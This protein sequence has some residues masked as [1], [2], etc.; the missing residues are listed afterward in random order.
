MGIRNFHGGETL[1]PEK[2]WP[3]IF[4]DLAEVI[5]PYIITGSGA[6]RSHPRHW[7]ITCWGGSPEAWW[8]TPRRQEVVVVWLK[9]MFSRPSQLLFEW[10]FW[11]DHWFSLVWVYILNNFRGL[12]F[13]WSWT[14]NL[15]IFMYSN[16]TASQ[17]ISK[18]LS[19]YQ[20]A[21]RVFSLQY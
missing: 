13:Q 12:V 1:G 2:K 8:V 7:I 14:S 19:L 11:K 3:K 17:S 18:P 9:N 5:S 4:S 15:Y 20:H 6:H 16:I 21:N 10:P